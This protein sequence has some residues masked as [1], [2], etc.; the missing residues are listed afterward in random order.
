[1][2]DAE[3]LLN[4]LTV[5]R[6]KFVVIGGLAMITRGSATVTE[7][8]DIC[9]CRTDENLRSVIAALSP[10]HPVLRNVPTGLP[11][12][13]DSQTWKAGLNFTLSTDYGSIDLLGEVP[14]IGQYGEVIR[15]SE[16]SLVY[17]MTISVL[18]IDGLIEAKRAAGRPKDQL[19]LLELLELKKLSEET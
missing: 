19:H 14:G 9:Y 17:G 1:M 10:I 12:I 3:K 13:W 15:K 16:A 5:E 6:V 4:R 7:D 11:F 2:F 18:S 8:L